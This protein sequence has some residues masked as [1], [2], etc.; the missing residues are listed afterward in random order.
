MQAV[1]TYVI[2]AK[3]F[4]SLFST[5]SQL[6]ELDTIRHREAE[7]YF[8]MPDPRAPTALGRPLYFSCFCKVHIGIMQAEN[9][10]AADMG[11]TSDPFVV[12]DMVHVRTHETLSR[13][14][15]FVFIFIIGLTSNLRDPLMK[16]QICVFLVNESVRSSG[17]MTH[18]TTRLMIG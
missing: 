8:M 12:V 7:K 14:V 13:C 17:S 6:Q 10:A 3:E 11:W 5:E 15:M 2:S 1:E 4:K 18:T 16:V 9:L